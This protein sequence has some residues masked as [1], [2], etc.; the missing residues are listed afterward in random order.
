LFDDFQYIPIIK[1][2]QPVSKVTEIAFNILHATLYPNPVHGGT[3]ALELHA[4]ESGIIRVE[5]FDSR[6]FAIR[7]M[8][9]SPKLGGTQLFNM[10]FSGIPSGIYFLRVTEGSR[11]KSLKVIVAN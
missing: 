8:F 10:D 2:C 7:Q 4:T 11:Q 5:L 6:G 3:A 1:N 9:Q